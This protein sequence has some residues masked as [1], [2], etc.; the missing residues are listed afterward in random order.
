MLTDSHQSAIREHIPMPPEIRKHAS[1]ANADLYNGPIYEPFDDGTPYSFSESASILAEW[2]REQAPLYLDDD[3]G[4]VSSTEPEG[5]YEEDEDRYYDPPPY[6]ELD[7][8][9]IAAAFGYREL[10]TYG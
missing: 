6:Y 7:A 3:S 10:Y 1:R 8:H 2:C 9:D 4:C 5:I